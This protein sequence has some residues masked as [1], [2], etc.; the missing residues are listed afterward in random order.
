MTAA[1]LAT[2]AVT[3]TKIATNAVSES[4]LQSDSVRK[5]TIQGGAVSSGKLDT[6]TASLAGSIP[7]N[8]TV[9]L[10][11]NPQCFWPMIHVSNWEALRMTGHQTDGADPDTPRFALD[12]ETGSPHTYDVDYRQIIA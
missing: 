8:D 5:R 6:V 10:T 12:N 9:H 7:A 4:K 1:K 2:G 11:L 3:V